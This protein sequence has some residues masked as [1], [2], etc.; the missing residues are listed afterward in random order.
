MEIPKITVVTEQE[1]SRVFA[2][3]LLSFSTD[4]LLR[5]LWPEALD[6]MNCTPAFD[7]FSAGAIGHGSAYRAENFEG[8]ALW[9][10]PGY[11]PDDEA[12]F[13]F[14]E[15]TIRPEVREDVFHVFEAMEEYHPSEPC[16]YLPVIGVDPACQGLGIGAALMKHSMLRP[17]EEGVPAY[18]ESSN[19]RNISLYQRHGFEVMGEIQFGSSPTISPMLRRVGG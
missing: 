4:P 16:W 8:A 17:D 2:S 11:G 10:P 13:S 12:F 9:F 19:P 3:L 14:L 1:R 7:A 5:W 18:L 15:K 6:Y